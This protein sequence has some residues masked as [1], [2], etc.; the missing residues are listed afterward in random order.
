MRAQLRSH[1]RASWQ[2]ALE[3]AAT[4]SLP[5]PYSRSPVK[6]SILAVSHIRDLTQRA[7]LLLNSDLRTA[8]HS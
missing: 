2:R 7:Y 3:E 4:Y 6:Q 5:A 8:E 1:S